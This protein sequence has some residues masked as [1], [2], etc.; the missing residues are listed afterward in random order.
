MLVN[1]IDIVNYKATLLSK[2]IQTSE[3]T[4]YDD[5]LRN[6]LN[7]LYL[8]K[9]EKYKQIKLQFLI[10]EIDNDTALN[11]ISNLV[12]QFGKCIVKFIDV[13][14]YYSCSIV[15][16]NNKKIINGVYTLD[17]ELKSGYAYKPAV[18][19]TLDHVSS[20]TINILGNLPSPAIVNVTVPV[21]TISLTLVGFG[22][23]PIIIKNLKANVPITI[24]GED[25]LVTQAGLN[26]FS[27]IDIWEFPTLQ[28]GANTIGISS[29]NCIIQIEYKPKFI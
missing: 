14:F 22:T 20:K 12:K 3:V 13:S 19:E 21:D 2:D 11:A 27:E 17:I 5:W 29:A 4:I 6:A 26:K 25:C 18:T 24:D 28:P 16:S 1:S 10:E 8:G 7:P 9:Q 15:N 23:D